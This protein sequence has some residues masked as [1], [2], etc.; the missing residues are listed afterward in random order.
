MMKAA[1]SGHADAP[2]IYGLDHAGILREDAVEHQT[3]SGSQAGISSTVD[4]LVAESEKFNYS[5]S[6]GY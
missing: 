2:G 3:D 5:G 6:D 1:D 4:R